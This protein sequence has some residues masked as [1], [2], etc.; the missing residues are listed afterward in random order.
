MLI[1]IQQENILA[2][3]LEEEERILM[4]L[5]FKDLFELRIPKPKIIGLLVAND[6]IFLEYDTLPLN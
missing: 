4:T 6:L 5:I 3:I 1:F 2:P